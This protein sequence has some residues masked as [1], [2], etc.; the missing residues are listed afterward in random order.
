MSVAITFDAVNIVFG[1]VIGFVLAGTQGLPSNDYAFVLAVSA[2]AV[3]AILSLGSQEH[4]LFYAIFAAGY[5][6]ALPIILTEF[7]KIADVP[8]LQPTLII[9]AIMVLLVEFALRKAAAPAP[10]ENEQ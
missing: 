6:G 2:A 8:K 5:I 1:A 7:L 10:L 3:I 9:W 4:R